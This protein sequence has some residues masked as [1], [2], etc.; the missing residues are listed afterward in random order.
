MAFMFLMIYLYTGNRK[1]VL[2]F[3]ASKNGLKTIEKSL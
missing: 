2:K 3:H 1:V